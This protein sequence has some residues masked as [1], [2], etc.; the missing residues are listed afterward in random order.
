M[1]ARGHTPVSLST[2]FVSAT[3]QPEHPKRRYL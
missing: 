2:T 1:L 3:R